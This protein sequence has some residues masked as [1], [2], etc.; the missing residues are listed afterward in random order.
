M[1]ANTIDA[2]LLIT[3]LDTLQLQTET[4]VTPS[5]MEVSVVTHE[6]GDHIDHTAYFIKDGFYYT[7]SVSGSS[8]APDI[9]KEILDAYE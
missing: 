3:G 9:L 7:V 6:V 1:C 5:G 4:Y 2:G 8:S